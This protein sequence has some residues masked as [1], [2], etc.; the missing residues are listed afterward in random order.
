MFREEIPY[1]EI[2]PN[3]TKENWEIGF[4][5]QAID[6]LKPSKYLVELAEKQ[7][8]GKISY[9]EVESSIGQ[10]Y[11]EDANIDNME[12][13]VTSMRISQILAM[14]GFNLSPV[15]LLNYHKFI[16]S[17]IREFHYPVGKFR[18][19]NIT[20]EEAVLNGDTV[21]YTDYPFLKDTLA[22]DLEQEQEKNYYGEKKADIAHS[23]MKFISGIWQIHPFREGNTRTIATFAIKYLRHLDFEVDNKPFQNHS[24]FFR[25]SLA[26]ANY[27]R[28]GKTD[29]YLKMFTENTLLNGSH[30]LE[31]ESI[32][33]LNNK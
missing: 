18:T 33:Q 13:D 22:Y 24:K 10:Y 4:G 32:D 12:A 5:L 3:Y 8:A 31:I 15:T 1:T 28:N 7:I 16:F 21:R 20:K 26:L 2:E 23:V 17:G 14:D 19:Q 25:D 29:K 30:K 27:H 6:G 9:E 11:K